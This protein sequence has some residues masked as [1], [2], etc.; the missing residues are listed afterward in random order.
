MKT[1]LSILR[2]FLFFLYIYVYTPMHLHIHKH[3]YS[4]LAWLVLRYSFKVYLN[5]FLLLILEIC[6]ESL[7]QS[8]IPLSSTV[9]CIAF[10]CTFS[11][12]KLLTI[13][14]LVL[15]KC[16]S[17]LNSNWLYNISGVGVS[18][19]FLTKLSNEYSSRSLTNFEI[20]MR[21]LHIFSVISV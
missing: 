17:L 3:S 8:Y 5:R 4:T 13:A 6:F 20:D 15:Y 11:K 12:V 18:E 7:F 2:I 1:L 19:T 14:C 10:D 9:R 16:L 21:L